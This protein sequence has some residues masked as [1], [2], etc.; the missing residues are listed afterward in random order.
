MSMTQHYKR[1]FLITLKWRTKMII[2]SHRGYWK[3]SKEKNQPSAFDRS[4]SLGFGTETDVRD[5]NGELVI[6]HDIADSSCMKLNEMLDIYIRYD[7]TLPLAI[8]IKSDGLQSKLSNILERYKISNY[9]VFDMSVPDG[10]QYIKKR[11]ATFTRESEY[12]KIPAFYSESDGVWLDAFKENWIN[13]DTVKN[14]LDNDK[15]ICIVSPD[16]HGRDY[17]S[18]WEKYKAIERKL[19]YKEIML[20]T[21]YPEHAEDFFNG[22]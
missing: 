13:F 3:S 15:K 22:K 19:N 18:E 12:E 17:H 9:F 10:L 1:Y 4:F 6:S 8:N 5:F 11:L 7:D 21:D 20:C 2:L 14:H 16:L